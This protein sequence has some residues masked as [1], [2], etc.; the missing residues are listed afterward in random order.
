MK[1]VLT[2]IVA[3][4]STWLLLLLA[5]VW[6]GQRAN[7]RRQLAALAERLQAEARIDELT[8]R[9]LQTMREAV[10]QR[11]RWPS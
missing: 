1:V 8:R 4:L 11:G 6:L 7:D 10:S 9:T 3:V 2:I 5:L